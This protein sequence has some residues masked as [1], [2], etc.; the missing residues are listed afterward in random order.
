MKR[1]IKNIFISIFA[2]IFLVS[3]IGLRP[4][5]Q[6]LNNADYGGN[7]N[8]VGVDINERTVEFLLRKILNASD[9]KIRTAYGPAKGWISSRQDGIINYGYVFI[10]EFS[11]KGYH[12]FSGYSQPEILYVLFRDGKLITAKSTADSGWNWGTV[13]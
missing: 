10:Y 2:T 12:L 7:P 6:E 5:Q 3:C 9:V 13:K 8:R 4:T 11:V 1:N